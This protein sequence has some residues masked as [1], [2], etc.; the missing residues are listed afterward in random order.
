MLTRLDKSNPD[1]GLQQMIKMLETTSH[2]DEI[3]AHAGVGNVN[4]VIGGAQGQTSSG[5]STLQ[6]Q[7]EANQASAEG[8]VSRRV[9]AEYRE[10]IRA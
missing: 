4:E 6:G 7:V 9:L 5:M 2:H 3:T 8:R 10:S 1:V